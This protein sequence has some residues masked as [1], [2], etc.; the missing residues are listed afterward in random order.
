MES[1]GTARARTVSAGKKKQSKGLA[2]RVLPSLRSWPERQGHLRRGGPN[3]DLRRR[4]SQLTRPTRP[5]PPSVECLP[6]GKL[7][8]LSLIAY[9]SL[10]HCVWS[11]DGQAALSSPA[12]VTNASLSPLMVWSVLV[13]AC[14]KFIVRGL[15][16][17]SP[18]YP[19]IQ[20]VY[21]L[22]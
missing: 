4:T 2:R 5:F 3:C 22:L 9:A 12:A 18:L 17:I 13:E 16:S 6:A 19:I 8:S 15:V 1:V 14:C 21:N 20:S 7:P 11:V 10:D